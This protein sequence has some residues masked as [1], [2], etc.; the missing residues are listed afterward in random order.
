MS[1]GFFNDSINFN[2]RSPHGERLTQSH[3]APA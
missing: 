1:L 3:N 2:P